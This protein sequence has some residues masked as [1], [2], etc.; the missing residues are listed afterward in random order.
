MERLSSTWVN[1]MKDG[2]QVCHRVFYFL[3]LDYS[4]SVVHK[5]FIPEVH[6]PKVFRGFWYNGPP[7]I[8]PETHP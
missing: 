5:T 3:E 1:S 8:A 4:F 7:Y 2:C 6:S